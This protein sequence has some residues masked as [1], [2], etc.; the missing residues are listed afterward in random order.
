VNTAWVVQFCL[1]HLRAVRGHDASKI[2]DRQ[3]GTEQSIDVQSTHAREA[4]A[5]HA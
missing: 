4:D 3:I 2:R 1:D 5:S